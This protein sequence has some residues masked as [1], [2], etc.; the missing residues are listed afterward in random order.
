[1]KNLKRV[2]LMSAAVAAFMFVALNPADVFAQKKNHEQTAALFPASVSGVL[3]NSCIG[4]HSDMSRG[5]AKEAMN[6]SEWDKFTHKEQVKTGK[7]MGRKVRK[8]TMPPPMFLEKH[9]EAALTAEQKVEIAN[10]AKSLKKK[11]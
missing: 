4:C 11:K 8:G 5:K 1:M 6:L 3:K 10:W 7:A 2:Y 9:P